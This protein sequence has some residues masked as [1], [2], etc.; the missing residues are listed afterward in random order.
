VARKK[1]AIDGNGK[2]ALYEMPRAERNAK[3][4]IPW[5]FRTFSRDER[6]RTVA[7]RSDLSFPAAIVSALTV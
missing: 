6:H 2:K 5:I 3:R 7:S 4:L 1:R